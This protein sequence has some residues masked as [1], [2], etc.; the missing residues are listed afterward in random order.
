MLV[1][2]ILVSRAAVMAAVLMIPGLAPASPPRLVPDAREPGAPATAAVCSSGPIRCHAHVRVTPTGEIQAEATP[3][4]A[5]AGLGPAQIQAAYQIDPSK[6]KPATVAIV[7]AFGYA[8]LESDLATY[9]AQ[10]GLPP[11]T[12]ASGCLTILNQDGA[13]A[14][15]PPESPPDN[16]WSEETALD[17]DAISAAC[18]T[19]KIIVVQANDNGM[20]MYTAQNAAAAARP[21]VISDSWGGATAMGDDRS[22]L[23]VFFTHPGIA[24]FVSSGDSGYDEG[25]E[26]P[27][28]PSTSAHTISVGGTTLVRAASARGWSE[29]AWA[30][31]GSSCAYTIPRPAYQ[32]TTA[33]LFRAASD[34]A[35]V[36]D[37]ATGL[38][39][40]NKRA[41]GWV[42]VGGTSAASPLVAALFASIGLGNITAADIAQRTSALFDVTSGSNGPCG[43]ILCNATTGWDGP[44]GF[45]TPSAALLSGAPAPPGPG[46]LDVKITSPVDGDLVDPGFQVSAT[47]SGAAVVGLFIDGTLLRT[48]TA[49]PYVF[50]TPTSLAFGTHDIAVVA[51]DAQDNQVVSEI[52]V[53][54]RFAG[55]PVPPPPDPETGRGG[56][57]QVGGDPA[58]GL[59]LLAGVLARRRRRA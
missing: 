3:L 22:P 54:V 45:G 10:F 21:T 12:R 46:T 11:C 44:T 24:Q 8:D 26:G 20:N 34:I 49:A 32:T 40:Y 5:P 35:A 9:R 16:D 15:L 13:T 43:T 47:A 51:Q 57:C 55:G 7:D 58:L 41:G 39:V 6:A 59:T 19:C 33:C 30:R 2:S 48:A 14:P 31:G 50:P 37:P 38:A 17:V 28:Y 29:T 42:V 1:R 25:G 53:H 36:G 27:T 56:G 4:A 23:E 18:P 52:R